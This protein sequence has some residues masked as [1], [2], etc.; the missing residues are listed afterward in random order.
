MKL[1]FATLGLLVVAAAS[2]DALRGAAPMML[3]EE[4]VAIDV[5]GD[6]VKSVW[7]SFKTSV[8]TTLSQPKLQAADAGCALVAGL[9]MLTNGEFVFKW[10]MVAAAGILAMLV[11]LS[12]LSARGLVDPHVRAMAAVEVFLVASYTGLKGLNGLLLG[13]G[14]LFGFFLA[15]SLERVLNLVVQGQNEEHQHIITAVWYSIFVLGCMSPVAKKGYTR[16]LTIIA[17][18]AGG[19]LVS[20]AVAWI[21]TTASVRGKLNVMSELVPDLQPGKEAPW[22]KFLALLVSSDAEDV[23]LF[24]NTPSDTF[25]GFWNLDRVLGLSLWFLLFLLGTVKQF[26]SLAKQKKVQ[27]REATALSEPLLDEE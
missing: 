12:E 10:I 7:E 1:A 21:V 8:A 24:A 3:S 19:A 13:V 6:S 23:G 16:F 4:P 22:Y 14:A 20:S 25:K 27:A 5:S 2:E 15:S 17:S 9:L 11:A 26:N 18:I